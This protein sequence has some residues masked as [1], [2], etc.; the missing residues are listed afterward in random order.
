MFANETWPGG[1]LLGWVLD[2]MYAGFR[3][4]RYGR[5]RDIETFRMVVDGDPV[6]AHGA[7]AAQRAA[8]GG[9][10]ASGG[11]AGGAGGGHDGSAA[12]TVRA[13][14]FPGS[15]GHAGARSGR[16]DRPDGPGAPR[17]GAGSAQS[18]L[19]CGSHRL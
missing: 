2:L 18:S 12:P 6:P 4:L 14:S 1:S 19:G 5:T 15:F 17:H 11:T 8:A 7:S 9:T 13:L 3:L 16:T 10:A